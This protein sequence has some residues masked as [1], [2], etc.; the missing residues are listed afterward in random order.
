MKLHSEQIIKAFF[1]CRSRLEKLIRDR[2]FFISE[3]SE[4]EGFFL[5]CPSCKRKQ[6]LYYSYKLAKFTCHNKE[7]N[8]NLSILYSRLGLARLEAKYKAL[9]A[10][11]KKVTLS[12]INQQLLLIIQ[13]KK[14]LERAKG[15]VNHNSYISPEELSRVLSNKLP[16]V[17]NTLPSDKPVTPENEV[18]HFEVEPEKVNPLFTSSTKLKKPAENIPPI[19]PTHENYVRYAEARSRNK[20]L[21]THGDYNAEKKEHAK[22]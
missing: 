14:N 18:K 16:N 6:T 17:V 2:K 22:K 19:P 7:E 12:K 5:P 11:Q 1:S 10:Q 8:C 9:F 15:K 21:S 4:G 13:A 3:D 20:I